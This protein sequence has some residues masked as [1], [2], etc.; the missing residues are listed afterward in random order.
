MTAIADLDA[1]AP[2]RLGLFIGV[3]TV[4]VVGLSGLTWLLQLNILVLGPVYMFTPL[5]A[6]VAVCWRHDI[7]LRTVGL[8]FGRWKWVVISAVCWPPIALLIAGASIVV[9]GV[10]IDH[11]II[12]TETGVPSEPLW[13]L[14]GLVGIIAVMLLSGVSINAV[15]AFGEEFGWRGYLL[16]ELAP[17]GFWKAS[18]VIGVMWGIWHA[19]LVL[20]GL[21]Y[22][23]FPV[24]GVFM[25]TVI[26]ILMSPLYTYLVARAESVLPAVFLHGVFN[27][28]GLVALAGTDNPFLRELVASEGGIVGVVVLGLLLVLIWR[29]GPD[30]IPMRMSP[31][32]DRHQS[33]RGKLPLIQSN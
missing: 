4:L 27:A 17:L 6:A 19:P 32:A 14:V 16:W 9:P 33:D 13:L 24:V 28:T 21:N 20:A 15:L 8:R 22:P 23:T 18:T 10:R 1:G 2:R 7:P 30:N 31:E 12:A 11:T 29:L 26:C 25:F 5:I 3:L